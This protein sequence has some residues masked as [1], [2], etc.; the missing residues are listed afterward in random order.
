MPKKKKK[1][2]KKKPRICAQCG[3]I[4]TRKIKRME[5][6]VP[7]FC[8][9]DHALTY[10]GGG[11]DNAKPEK[12]SPKQITRLMA[13]RDV[14]RSNPDWFINPLF[15]YIGRKVQFHPMD[16]SIFYNPYYRQRTGRKKAIQ[17]FES[18]FYRKIRS[19][20]SFKKAVEDIRGKILVCWCIPPASCH[21]DV[22][23]N[24]LHQPKTLEDYQLKEK[25][26][27]Q[28]I[29]TTKTDLIFNLIRLHEIQQ[30]QFTYQDRINGVEGVKCRYVMPDMLVNQSGYPME[31][32]RGCLL[33]LNVLSNKVYWN[34]SMYIE[35]KDQYIKRN[36]TD[37]KGRV[38]N[39]K[40]SRRVINELF[41]VEEEVTDGSSDDYREII[42]SR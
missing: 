14:K 28:G 11:N 6:G 24:Y 2:K 9:V 38:K 15:V 19:D 27:P 36:L 42:R 4:I 39:N 34:G 31:L 37:Y 5:K 41:G 22:I 13:I 3:K 12:K 35:S 25:E 23:I 30:N 18:Y 32:V 21:G 17:Q 26:V 40:Y 29:D 8:S 16:Q 20:S 10:H 7:L 1:K 33:S